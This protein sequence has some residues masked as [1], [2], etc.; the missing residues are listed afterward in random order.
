MDANEHEFIPSRCPLAN[1]GKTKRAELSFRPRI[2]FGGPPALEGDAD[3][4]LHFP[5]RI[6]VVE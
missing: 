6:E 2:V 3:A 5:A 4:E 1:E